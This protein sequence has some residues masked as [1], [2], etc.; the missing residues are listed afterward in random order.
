MRKETIKQNKNQ[1]GIVMPIYIQKKQYEIPPEG[2]HTAALVEIRDLGVCQT[3]YG[4]SHM[5]N[6]GWHL[7][8]VKTNSG[9]PFR[10]DRKYSLSFSSKSAL[11]GDLQ[12]WLGQLPPDSFD[13]ETLVGRLAKLAIRHRQANG[14]TYANILAVLPYVPDEREERN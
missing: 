12:S 9:S 1:K 6:L 14:K 2:T 11:S 13:L 4:E 8:H 7:K 10:L 3:P 5:I